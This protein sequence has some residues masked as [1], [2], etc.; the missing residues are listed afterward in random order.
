MAELF[1][2]LKR[3]SF[4]NPVLFLYS[5]GGPDH[6]LTY[7]SVRL[8]LISL[9]LKFDLDYLCAGRTA[10][11]HSWH[12]PVERIM[13]IL[14][15]GLQCVGL[16]RSKM[17]DEFEAEVTKRNN[18][19]ELRQHLS[20]HKETVNDSLSPVKALLHSLFRRLQ[21][22]EKKFAIYNTATSSELSD[23]WSSILAFDSTL[24]EGGTYRKDNIHNYKRICEFMTHCCQS[25]HYTFDI[26][27]CGISSCT[28]CK[29][30]RLPVATFKK[31]KH[32]PHPTPMEDGHYLP[33]A[34][35]FEV[36]TSEEHRPSLNRPS[37]AKK[38]RT[39]P[40]YAT[41]QHVKNANIMVQCSEC[42]M[43]RLVFSQ[44][45]LDTNQRQE[46]QS[47][48]SDYDYS[49]GTSLKDLHLPENFKTVEIREH[50]CSDPIERLYYTAKYSPICV[51]CAADQPYTTE[52][53]YPQCASC[54]DK[55]PIYKK[56]KK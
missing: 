31:L 6:R 38:K 32:I 39:L 13:S 21:L 15:L 55:P 9:F 24:T 11:Y 48:L 22:H 16:A 33:F 54:N 46:L 20:S 47:V 2:V 28:I 12:N 29:P 44:F 17:S 27:K 51:Y 26:L 14:N 53:E 3:S 7:Y 5:D 45:K 41:V 19:T 49:C 30:P 1:D 40:F 4:A 56:T 52:N 43:W 36:T 23:F 18:M 10:P 50:D 25:A 37:K 8:S 42:K 34:E 35:A